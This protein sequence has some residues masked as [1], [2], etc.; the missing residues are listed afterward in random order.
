MA[1]GALSAAHHLGRRVPQEL[2][3][4][5]DDDIPEAKYFTPPLTSIRQDLVESGRQLVYELDCLIQAQ[6]HNEVCDPRTVVIPPQ[7]IVR[8][9]SGV[10]M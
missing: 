10:D 1:L 3:V 5:G 8:A 9:S 2:G 6:L 7:L 4:V